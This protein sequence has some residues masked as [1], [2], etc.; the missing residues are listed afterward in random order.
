MLTALEERDR[1]FSHSKGQE[2]LLSRI[3]KIMCASGAKNRQAYS[4]YYRTGVLQLTDLPINSPC[5]MCWFNLVLF[6]VSCGNQALGTSSV[7]TGIL[8][9][10]TLEFHF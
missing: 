2:Y 9:Q 10:L 3:I 8:A 1:I 5:G 7:N 6:I 4:P